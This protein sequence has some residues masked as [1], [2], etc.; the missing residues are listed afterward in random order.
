LDQAERSG[1]KLLARAAYHRAIDLGIQ[2]V[3]DAYLA[4]RPAEN[5]A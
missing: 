3:V 2:S 4:S 1:D 5:R